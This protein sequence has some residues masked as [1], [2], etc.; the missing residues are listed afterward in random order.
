MQITLGD[1]KRATYSRMFLEDNEYDEY[2][3]SILLGINHGL[4]DL[5]NLFPIK[6]QYE[7]NQTASTD[8]GENE[9]DIRT[10]TQEGG[11]NKFIR[12]ANPALL[13]VSGGDTSVAFDYKIIADRYLHI[14]KNYGGTFKVQYY[15]FPMEVTDSTNDNYVFDID[16]E[17]A[18]L[19]PLYATWWAMQDDDIQTATIAYNEYQEAKQTLRDKQNWYSGID[20]SGGYDI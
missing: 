11:V 7:I 19:L 10:L 5:A 13:V 3:E 9:Y 4:L 6:A 8:E 1:V 2:D 18:N 16:S 17:A 20:I 14:K 15:R 12:F